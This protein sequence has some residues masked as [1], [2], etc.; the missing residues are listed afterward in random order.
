[1]KMFAK[2]KWLLFFILIMLSQPIFAAI[3]GGNPKGQVTL[4][5]FFDYQ[6]PHCQA[7]SNIVEALI[8]ENPNLRI[9]YR[10]TPVLGNASFVA[11]RIVLAARYQNKALSLHQLLMADP[12]N[13]SPSHI[14]DLAAQLGLNLTQLENDQK[15]E[16]ISEEI[17]QN[18][19]M[20]G[21]L[22]MKGVPTFFIGKTDVSIN[23]YQ[24]VDGEV[25]L[26]QLQ[27]IISDL[28]PKKLADIS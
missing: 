18:F 11:A 26:D 19:K 23:T 27:V 15:K 5:E 8:R 13:L 28:Q 24:R 10:V 7:M 17:K 4:V 20:A 9:V 6:C 12:E 2:Y 3:V 14:Y 22:R 16:A 25:K 21:E 1:M